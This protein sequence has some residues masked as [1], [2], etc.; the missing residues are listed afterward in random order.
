MKGIGLVFAG[1]GGKGSYEIGVWKYLHEVGLDQYV[2]AVSGT[3]VGALNA[4]LFVGSN[5]DIAEDLWKRISNDK[6]LSPKKISIDDIMEYISVI[7]L[8]FSGPIGQVLNKSGLN[9][10]SGAS[11]GINFLSPYILRWVTSDYF[12]S[13]DGLVDLIKEGIIFS[14]LQ[15]NHIPCFVTCVKCSSLS[16]ERFDLRNYSNQKIV[17][18]LL[19]TSAIP[20]VFPNEEFEG[21][22]YCDGG[23]PFIGD[24]VPIQPIYDMG[25]EHI[26]VIYLDQDTIIDREKYI[27]SKIIEIMP[28]VDLGNALNGVLDFTPD[29]AKKRIIQG[30]DDAKRILQPMINMLIM[31]TVNKAILRKAQENMQKFEQK[32]EALKKVEQ[33]IK[34][35]MDNDGFDLLYIDLMKGK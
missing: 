34:S 33:Q 30:Y 14:Q 11:V 7:A 20:I 9:L 16:V 17:N 24:N 26:I 27:N 5:Y 6:I 3:S 19:A 18:L 29:G 25:I 12:F 2:R 22:K 28:S 35:E 23:V 15:N 10:K 31:G 4:A 13:R 32:K 1:G 21:N 8:N